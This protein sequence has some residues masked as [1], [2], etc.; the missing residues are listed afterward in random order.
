MKASEV[1]EVIKKHFPFEEAREGQLEIILKA[2]K[3]YSSGKKYVIL[4]APTG[5]GKSVIGYTL[6]TMLN[7][8]YVLTSQKVLQHQYYDDFKIPF[9]LGRANY[10]CL[11]M[12]NST[13]DAGWCM[14]IAEKECRDSHGNVTC[15]Y[16]ISKVNALCNAHSNLSYAYLLALNSTDRGEEKDVR[17]L[18]ICDEAH[19]LEKELLNVYHLNVRE[20]LLKWIGIE[21]LSIPK[22][23]IDDEAAID[24][25][26]KDLASAVSTITSYWDGKVKGLVKLKKTREFK[27]AMQKFNAAKDLKEKLSYLQALRA[28]N[29]TLVVQ[30]E[31]ETS[32]AIK[33]LCCK[34]IFQRILDPL[35]LHFLFMSATILNPHKFIE[36]L[37]LEESLCEI[38]ECD[39]PF[40]VENRLIH[41]EPVGSLSYRSKLATMPKLIA[42]IDQILKKNP[43]VK[44]II[45]TVNYEIAD[46]IVEKLKFSSESY[47]LILPKGNDKQMLLDAFYESQDPL[48]LI[49]PSL[50]EGIDLKDEL[51]RLCIICKVPYP[52]LADKW[53][54]TKMENDREW[55]LTQT[56][57]TLVQM[58]GRSIRSK[59]DFAT[60]YILDSDFMNL[61]RNASDIL[62]DWWKESVVM[63]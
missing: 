55:Y 3:A 15:P 16:L 19:T 38:I 30:H 46:M 49:S 54:K 34:S 10:Q 52:S 37:G 42:K 36:T 41:F 40:P 8:S 61:A 5:V 48:I 4:S 39:S 22:T 51:S 11:K 7:N 59:E 28:E 53:T 17:N 9:V 24:W 33:P 50:T 29:Q 23:F 32:I 60:T 12:K 20:S 2:L 27:N 43:N 25:T 62:P 58:S 45:H 35:G 13:C 44:G 6:A 47:R 21:G 56:C 57:T 26:L 1:I 18:I 14:G 31:P 63:S